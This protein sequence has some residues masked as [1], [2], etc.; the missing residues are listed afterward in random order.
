MKQGQGLIK[1]IAVS[2]VLIS[3]Y[4]LSFTVVGSMF[5]KAEASYIEKNVSNLKG[6]VSADS[7]L[8]VSN[9]YKAN[10]RDSFS[11]KAF[12]DLFILKYTYKDISK[13]R[14][15]LGL[16]LKGGMSFVMAINQEEIMRALSN[17]S[18]DPVFDQALKKATAMQTGSQDN[19]LNLVAD[20]YTQIDP[21]AK[22]APIFAGLSNYQDKIKPTSSNQEVLNVLKFDMN[23]AL[24]NTYNVLKSRIDQFGVAE[25]VITL[26]EGTGRII[27]ELPGADD[28]QRVKK[29][30][31][32]SAKLEFWYTYD[33]KEIAQDFIKANETIKGLN[34]LKKTTAVADT[35]KKDSGTNALVNKLTSAPVAKDSANDKSNPLFEKFS[36]NIDPKTG[37]V[38]PGPILGFAA[39]KDLEKVMEMLSKE[40]VKKDFK[41]DVR[42]VWGAQ[43]TDAEGKFYPLYAIK[44]MGGQPAL[45][46]DAITSA[47]KESDQFGKP[48]IG[49]V[50]NP[51]GASTWEKMTELAASDPIGNKSIAIVLDNVVYSAPRVQN[52]I[53]GGRSA[54][55]GQF[56]PEEAQDLANILNSGKI[57]AP[58]KIIQEEVVGPSLGQ[59]TIAAGVF[60]L[61]IGLGLILAYMLLLYKKPGGLANISLVVNLLFL[62]GVLASLKAVLTL[63]GIAGIVL[64]IGAAV[65]ANVI[66]FERVKEELR[67][68]SNYVQALIN[69]FGHS[70]KTI[71]DA[72][73]TTLI[74]S[75]TLFFFGYGPIKGFAITLTIGIFTSI[76][77][78]VFLT[79]E[80]FNYNLDKK[81]EVPFTKSFL[82]KYFDNVN[83]DF[84]GKRRIAYLFSSA[85]IIIGLVAI[86]TVGF[87]L[88][89]DFKG[90]RS[91]VIT[92]DKNVDAPK[93]KEDLDKILD[94]KTIVKAYGQANQVQITTS[95]LYGIKENAIESK[96]NDSVV[97]SKVY[98]GTKAN[99]AKAVNHSDFVSSKVSNFRKIDATIADDIQRSA[100]TV[101]LIAMFLIFLYVS[102]RFNRWQYAAGAIAALLHDLFFTLGLLSLLKS[103]VPFSLEMN[104]SIIAAVLT[105]IGFSTN[106][107]VVIFDRIREF[108]K[109]NPN[110]K[111]E[112][113]INNAINDTLSRTTTTAS[114]LFL[115]S[116]VLFVFG[117]ESIRGFSFTML[118]GIFVG[119]V[120]SI[121][122]ASPIALDLI[123][124]F[125]NRKKA[126]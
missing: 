24:G 83:F 126:K 110:E 28:I 97:L 85:F 42:F 57:D 3:L 8:K 7:L 29:L 72:N 99:F 9:S 71:F 75:L 25:A 4:Y 107:T 103:V 123:N 94:G 111:L 81:N 2:M 119:T 41:A 76:F 62:L 13:F 30:L 113:T 93:I 39:T 32:S 36:L 5:D 90:G 37:S 108:V 6:N 50:M 54:I 122:I 18:K 40:E 73:A 27:V 19:Y 23:A 26:Q 100:K 51:Q 12:L 59:D 60:S 48:S 104:Q 20:A 114:T 80:F 44:A 87:D 98:E 52:K 55:T 31:E 74:T 66:I 109:R 68:G 101:T 84:I 58:A 47:Q 35:T 115:V 112:K 125:D 11:D 70:Y 95:Y 49:M 45:T 69:G 53:S 124:W 86:F 102:V 14:I 56:T 64:I 92:F 33:N 117:G 10:F 77:T 105:I 22:L 116:M 67:N 21:N 43:P 46:G 120:S 16:D 91:Y 96:A 89:V 65:D 63:P 118:I 15:K 82:D 106:D 61:M 78:A 88:G 34:A 79:R 121:F 1:F 17:N 38:F